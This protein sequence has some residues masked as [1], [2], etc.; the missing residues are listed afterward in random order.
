VFCERENRRA[1]TAEVAAVK[2]PAEQ[3]KVLEGTV[4]CTSSKPL[5]L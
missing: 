4:G 1:Y 2:Q 5:V 3:V